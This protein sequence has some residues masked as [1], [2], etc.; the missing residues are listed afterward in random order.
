MNRK[1]VIV[2]LLASVP[3]RSGCIKQ[4]RQEQAI[5]ALTETMP[6]ASD[7]PMEEMTEDN[8]GIIKF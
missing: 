6:E 5:D 1:R 2:L 8:Q 4:P 3:L 7:S